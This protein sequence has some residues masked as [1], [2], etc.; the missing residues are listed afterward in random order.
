[1]DLSKLM[2][3]FSSPETV[4]SLQLSDKIYASLITTLLGM[5]ITFSALIILLFVISFMRKLAVKPEPAAAITPPAAIQKEE[6]NEDELVAAITAA[7]VATMRCGRR[8]IMIR[9]IKRVNDF[10]PQWNRTGIHNQIN[11]NLNL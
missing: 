9:N 4:E 10:Q 2:Q 6:E 5:G 7:V 11:S 8:N 1:M 3:L